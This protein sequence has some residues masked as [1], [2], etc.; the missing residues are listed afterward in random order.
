MPALADENWSA[1]STLKRRPVP[2][3]GGSVT[4]ICV[5]LS[6]VQFALTISEPDGPNVT[7]CTS[8]RVPLYGIGPKKSPVS[9]TTSPPLTLAAATGRPPAA[10]VMV[11]I[12][13][14][15]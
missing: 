6:A 2:V 5:S 13:G 10:Y 8:G 12:A 1:T 9:S 11:L 7:V 3:P 14:A 15:A 4:R